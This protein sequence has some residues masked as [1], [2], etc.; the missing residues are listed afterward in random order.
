MSSVSSSSGSSHE[1]APFVREITVDCVSPETEFAIPIDSSLVVIRFRV[2]VTGGATPVSI[3]LYPISYF[4]SCACGSRVEGT[5]N[6]RS[7]QASARKK[8]KKRT[9][10][11][12]RP[13]ESLM[14]ERKRD[15][16]GLASVQGAVAVKMCDLI[17]ETKKKINESSNRH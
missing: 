9:L 2:R 17:T 11:L 16:S 15:L 3:T 1:I 6:K 12:A 7:I 5:A 13:P 10:Q 4:R 8:I 14:Q